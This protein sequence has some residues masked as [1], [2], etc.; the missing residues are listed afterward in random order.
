MAGKTLRIGIIGAGGIVRQRH[1]PGLKKIPGVE[2]AV[3]CNRGRESAERAA[4]EFGIPEIRTNWRDVVAMPDL[5][6][7]LIG[8]PPYLHAE[9]TIAALEAG[10]HVFCQARM[11]RNYA[12]A[13][14]MYE[15]SRQVERVTML[16]PPPQGMKGDRVMRKLI[17]EGFLGELRDVHATGFAA[18]YADSGAPLH[19]RQDFDLS[20]YNTLTLGMWIE[21][22]HRWIGYHRRVV[23][24]T[25]VHTAERRRPDGSERVTVRIPESV[26]ISAET[27]SGAVAVYHFSGVARSAPHNRIELYGSEGTLIY[28]L[29]TDEILGARAGDAGLRPI[30]IPRETAREWTVEQEFIDGIREGKPVEPSFYDGVKYMEFTEAVARAAETGRAVELPFEAIAPPR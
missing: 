21:V 11:A 6:A 24:V 25:R 17:G 19:W 4:A 18:G 7:I 5:D 27:T 28:D 16:C 9:A 1:Y 22:I 20:G 12:E 26:G 23:A 13:K 3:V 14:A 2:L 29:Q 10:K 30:P 15:R 8:T